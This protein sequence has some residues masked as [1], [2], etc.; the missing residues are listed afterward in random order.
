M[1]TN[2]YLMVIWIVTHLLNTQKL[3]PRE[4][5]QYK[6]PIKNKHSIF[7]ICF[8]NFKLGIKCYYM[9]DKLF[10]LYWYCNYFLHVMLLNIIYFDEYSDNILDI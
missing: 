8:K 9:Y 1:Y 3:I 5:K 4:T 2:S 6:T 7:I 10:T